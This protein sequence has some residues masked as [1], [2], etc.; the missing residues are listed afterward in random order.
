MARYGHIRCGRDRFVAQSATRDTCGMSQVHDGADDDPYR[1]LEDVTGPAAL[2]WAR[3]R[4]AETVAEMK[5]E[6]EAGEG[7]RLADLRSQIRQVLDADDRIPL[8]RRRGTYLYNF[9]QD[10]AHPRGLWRRTT[11]EEDRRGSRPPEKGAVRG[12][13]AGPAGQDKR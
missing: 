10:A 1:W 13:A 11:L 12:G 7:S 9:W 6:G 2:D 5:G 4:N 8:V 3:E